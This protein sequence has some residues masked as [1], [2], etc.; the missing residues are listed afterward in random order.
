MVAVLGAIASAFW[1]VNLSEVLTLQ[2]RVSNTEDGYQETLSI[3]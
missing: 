2:S 1:S 3:K